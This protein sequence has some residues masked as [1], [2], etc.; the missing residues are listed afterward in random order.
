MI[1]PTLDDL[2]NILSVTLMCPVRCTPHVDVSISCVLCITLQHWHDHCLLHH[3]QTRQNACDA[4]HN[5]CTR[6][7]L[8]YRNIT[9][10]ALLA[11]PVTPKHSESFTQMRTK[12]GGVHPIVFSSLVPPLHRASHLLLPW[13]HATQRS[14]IHSLRFHQSLFNIDTM[15]KKEVHINEGENAP[16]LFSFQQCFLYAEH[17]VSLLHHG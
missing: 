1:V 8:S 11:P 6:A 9:D 12:R 15:E 5:T 10:F 16:S 17:R 3:K 2:T 7:G 14:H 13:A 4:N